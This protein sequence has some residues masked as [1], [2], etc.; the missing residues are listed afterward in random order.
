MKYFWIA[1]LGLTLAACQSNTQQKVQLKT[2]QDSISY[3]IGMDIGKNLKMQFIDVDPTIIR[4]AR[5]VVTVLF[6]SMGVLVYLIAW[7]IIP[8]H[9][10]NSRS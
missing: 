9:Q 4:L 5:A 2:Q 1:V 6:G 10:T 8:D 3:S 7:I